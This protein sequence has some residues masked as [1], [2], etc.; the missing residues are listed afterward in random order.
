MSG[1]HCET[2][3]TAIT[4]RD[5]AETVSTTRTIHLFLR[6]PGTPSYVSPVSPQKVSF[7]LAS[8]LPIGEGILLRKTPT[9][10]RKTP[11]IRGG[12]EKP[13]TERMASESEGI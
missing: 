3:L 13:G 1:V 6:T 8:S 12:L 2:T 11:R 5:R 7:G 9:V 4:T 10:K